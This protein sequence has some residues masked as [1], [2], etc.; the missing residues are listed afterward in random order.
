[1]TVFAELQP[2]IGVAAACVALSINRS[3]VYRAR[4]R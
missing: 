1:M 2:R 4:A 3:G